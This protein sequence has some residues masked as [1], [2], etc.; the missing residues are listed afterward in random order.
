MFT[1]G[2][3]NGFPIDIGSISKNG[4][5][6][7]SGTFVDGIAWGGKRGRKARKCQKTSSSSFAEKHGEK[8]LK[9]REC[10]K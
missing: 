1:I 9:E 4:K 2:I 7:G 5:A 3:E 8:E 6:G 10:W